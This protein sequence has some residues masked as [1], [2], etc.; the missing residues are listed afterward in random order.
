LTGTRY[1]ILHGKHKM[2]LIK[3]EKKIHFAK[4]SN[5]EHNFF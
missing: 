1:K 4:V 5:L 3:T 2:K